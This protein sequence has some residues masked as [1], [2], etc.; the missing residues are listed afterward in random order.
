MRSSFE[1][2][3]SE[4]TL[5]SALQELKE[6]RET[7]DFSDIDWKESRDEGRK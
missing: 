2:T 7:L 6:I 3:E 5:E 1:Y 4:I